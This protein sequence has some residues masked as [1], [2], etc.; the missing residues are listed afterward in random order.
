MDKR[1]LTSF[2]DQTTALGYTSGDTTLMS[3]Q[4]SLVA[5]EV[6][7]SK[8]IPH[9][10]KIRF[11][12]D[13][14][15]GRLYFI[16]D[17]RYL[18]FIAEE[19]NSSIGLAK[20]STNQTL[21]YSTDTTTWNTFDTTTNITLAKAGDEVYVRG[22]LRADNTG[23]KYTQFEMSG[24]ISASGNCNA[25]WNYQDLNTP[26]KVYCGYRMFYDCTSLTTAPEL[27]ATELADMCYEQM[28]YNCTSLTTSPE[29]PA[30]TL[31]AQCYDGMFKGCSSLTVAPELPA[32]VLRSSCYQSM[33][34]GCTSLTVAPELPAT[35][36][37]A[38]CYSNMFNG[39]ISLATA[40]KLPAT[41][42]ANRCYIGMFK[43]CSSLT[44]AP[45]LPATILAPYCYQYMFQS[46]TSLSHIKCLAT[47]ISATYCTDNWV[48]GGV[49]STGTFVKHPDMNDWTTGNS[50][51]PSGWTVEDTYTP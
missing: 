40:P 16:V 44:V 15:T 25:I 5:N 33:F 32:T 22:I 42:L 20:L 11:A 26:L 6:V 8:E 29:L 35:T 21:E 14:E 46:C 30:T 43:G 31:A 24:K 28:F 37:A 47:D 1:Y 2:E 23:R 34:N 19:D 48:Y 10:S 39:C 3:P 49:S 36:L 27:P 18:T 7:Y 38:A 9:D 45:E 4:V 41:T 50:G 17:Q 12:K 13:E 51:I